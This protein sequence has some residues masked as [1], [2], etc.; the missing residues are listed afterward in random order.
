MLESIDQEL[1]EEEGVVV[2]DSS[3]PLPPPLSRT[4]SRDKFDSLVHEGIKRTA[5]RTMD[6]LRWVVSEGER[7][8][9]GGEGTC[10][11]YPTI[12][13]SS[14]CPTLFLMYHYRSTEPLTLTV[15]PTHR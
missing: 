9:K 15:P 8:L 1:D 12:T 11:F 6:G 10:S 14:K 13:V 5:D 7:V 3:P 4:T 2:D